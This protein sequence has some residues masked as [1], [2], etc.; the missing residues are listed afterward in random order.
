MKRALGFARPYRR[1]LVIYFSIIVVGTLVAALPPKVFQA[2]IDKA[3]P[4]HD[5]RL[6]GLLVLAAATL[7]LGQTAIGILNR[8]LASLIGEGLIYDLRTRLYDHVQGMPLAFFT[9]TQTGSLLSRLSSDVL[10]AQ[11]A[12][13]TVAT[14]FSDVF[15]LVV[16]LSFMWAIS[17]SVTLL[18]LT[19]VPL[20]IVIDRRLGRR[21]VALSRARMKINASMSTTMTERFN[22]AGALLVKL[23]GR[24]VAEAAEF[25]NRAGDVRDSGVKLAMASRIYYG[26]LSLVGGL[27]TIAVYWLGGR[28]V[29]SGTM[30]IGALTALSAYVTRLYSPLTDLATARVD[31]LTALVSFERVFEVLDAPRTITDKP[32]AITLT[33]PVGRIEVDDVH[34]R[35]PAPAD[36]SLASLEADASAELRHE[37]SDWILKGVTFT[38]EPGKMVALVG[39]SGAGKTTLTS[40]IPRLYDVTEGAI[41]IDGHDVRDRKSVV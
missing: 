39:P 21:L 16:T 7:T 27:G 38:A 23:F 29:I 6:L 34:F 25:A 15:T 31:L 22:V 24:P 35:Y 33:D 41:R 12:V 40:L 18:S 37:P 2:L 3:I 14:V 26:S 1:A 28:S 17:P 10:G 30:T 5:H 36:V 4:R 8:W 9:R 11:Q 20:I 32:G 19:I 13:G